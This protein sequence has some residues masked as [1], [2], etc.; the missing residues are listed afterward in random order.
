[1]IRQFFL[2]NTLYYVLGIAISI[3]GTWFAA[4]SI[5]LAGAAGD[6]F[7]IVFFGFLGWLFTGAIGGMVSTIC[8][9]AEQ[10][11]SRFQNVTVLAFFPYLAHCATTPII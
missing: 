3:L 10:R 2:T 8:L 9:P 4:N 1:M 6:P 11:I 5:L 7:A